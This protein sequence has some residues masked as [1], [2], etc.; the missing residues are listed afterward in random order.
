MRRRSESP[1]WASTGRIAFVRLF[2]TE[3]EIYSLESNGHDLRR[4]THTRGEDDD[5]AWSG[6]G[7]HIAFSSDRAGNFEIYVM[8]ADGGDLRR[9]TTSRGADEYG[10]AWS[11]DGTRIA[12]WRRKD[13]GDSIVVINSD[14]TN[15]HTISGRRR[16]TEFP[17]WSPDGESIAYVRD[18]ESLDMAHIWVM[19]SDGSEKHKLIDGP[20][21][22]PMELDW[23]QA[24]MR[25]EAAA[26]ESRR[27]RQAKKVGLRPW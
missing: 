21:S 5:P 11:P 10:P 7:Q 23:T 14:G 2:P 9:V 22:E 13:D 1:D 16:D 25:L 4:L 15:E 27:S 8:N 19:R 18:D 24:A 26:L 6:D 17:A 3:T 20:F 12:F